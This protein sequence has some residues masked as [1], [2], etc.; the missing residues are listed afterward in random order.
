MLKSTKK[1]VSL[2]YKSKCCCLSG[3]R[4]SKLPWGYNENNLECLKFKD[5]V[6]RK[7]KEFVE[8]G[9][10]TFLTGMAE[11]FDMI[12]TEILI[13]MKK[14]YK[15]IQVIAVIPCFNQEKLWSDNQQ[16]RYRYI[17]EE[18]DKTIVISES[19]SRTC[20]QER[21]EYM[22]NHSSVVFAC[23]DNISSGGTKNT[24][25]YAKLK[26]RE[27]VLLNPNDI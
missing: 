8:D 16:K 26:N 6:R 7:L 20:M 2:Y 13:E 4:P 27:I 3:H 14:S 1:K 22:V 17:L 19:Y 25:E 5:I 24:I 9:I 15:D 10:T 21:N 18:C 11:G 23:Y 12:A